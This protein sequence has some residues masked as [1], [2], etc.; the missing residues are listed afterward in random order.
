VV[1]SITDLMMGK[2][3]MEEI[4]VNPGLDNLHIMTC[5]TIAPNPAELVST[6][7]NAEVIRETREE[8]DFV[9]IDAPPVLAATDAALWGTK[10]DGV[11]IVYQVGKVAR[12]ALKRAKAQ[13]D[14]VKA[15]IIGVVLNGLKAEISPDF[16]YHD[17]YYY[18]Y[19]S[20][21]KRPQTIGQKVMTWPERIEVYFKDLPKRLK[22]IGKGDEAGKSETAR[23]ETSD[24]TETNGRSGVKSVKLPIVLLILALGLLLAGLYYSGLISGLFEPSVRSDSPTVITPPT[25]VKSEPAPIV[26]SIPPA[27]EALPPAGKTS[28][29]PLPV[30]GSAATLGEKATVSPSAVPSSP[31][32]I[33]ADRPY[34]IQVR[35]TKDARIA[36]D[37][38]AALKK[39]GHDAYSEI[40]D[41][42]NKGTWYRIFIGAFVSE[43]EALQYVETKKIASVYPDFIIHKTERSDKALEKGD[44]P[45]EQK[46]VPR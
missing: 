25:E 14:N 41:L 22:K 16:E 31:A 42:K 29:E 44:K 10:A 33:A 18:Y 46:S 26:P 6:K 9:I 35:A 7:I 36:Q 20:E 37:T 12:G 38:V 1:R 34:A 39:R 17:K 43:K 11:I 40:A 45:S 2:M 32:M 28:S 13:I 5:G 27:V 21:K 24:V 23:P 3:T 19:G 8:Y 4:M 15:K 30:Q